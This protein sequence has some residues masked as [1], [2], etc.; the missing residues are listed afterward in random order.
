MRLAS[1]SLY[2]LS[3]YWILDSLYLLSLYLRICTFSVFTWWRKTLLQKSLPMLRQSMQLGRM[4]IDGIRPPPHE[5]VITTTTSQ[6]TPATIHRPQI[7]AQPTAI[8]RPPLVGLVLTA[9]FL[10]CNCLLSAND[11]RTLFGV[12]GGGGGVVSSFECMSFLFVCTFPFLSQ[13]LCVSM[14]CEC[15]F[16]YFYCKLVIWATLHQRKFVWSFSLQTYI[17]DPL[18]Q[19]GREMGHKLCELSRQNLL[20]VL[21]GWCP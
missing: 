13:V 18:S 6:A 5:V 11:C 1:N 2:W 16:I 9:L 14:F 10:C 17:F 20:L 21:S 19:E 7:A 8:V 3:L 12:G 4:G 15:R